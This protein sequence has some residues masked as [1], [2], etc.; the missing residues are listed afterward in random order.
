MLADEFGK[1]LGSLDRPIRR[2]SIF[3]RN[4]FHK[5][6]TAR[7]AWQLYANHSR[8][9]HLAARTRRFF[10]CRGRVTLAQ[11]ERCDASDRSRPSQ[12][13]HGQEK[14]ALAKTPKRRAL[15]FPRCET[16]GESATRWD[17]RPAPAAREASRSK[18]KMHHRINAIMATLSPLITHECGS[19]FH[20]S[21][22]RSA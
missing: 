7:Q 19:K 6:S 10:G 16:A 8:K 4:S 2:T 15:R 9:S 12:K 14:E 20:P 17:K 21:R 5:V 22:K 11:T 3:A 13:S 1:A 18:N